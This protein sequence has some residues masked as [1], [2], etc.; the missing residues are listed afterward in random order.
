MKPTHFSFR[1]LIVK[2]LEGNLSDQKLMSN[3]FDTH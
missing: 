2:S 3:A 1:I